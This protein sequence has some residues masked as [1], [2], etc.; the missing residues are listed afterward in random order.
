MT[1]KVKSPFVPLTVFRSP[2]LLIRYLLP[3]VLDQTLRKPYDKRDELL[4]KS[5]EG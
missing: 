3:S 1:P 4:P 5:G 2:Q